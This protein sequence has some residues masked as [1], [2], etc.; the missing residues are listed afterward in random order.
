ML[1]TT[2]CLANFGFATALLAFALPPIAAQAP[3]VR[4]DN[5]GN[6]GVGTISPS[7]PLHV[8]DS[9]AGFPQLFTLEN[10]GSDFAGFRL[11]TTGGSIDFNKA[12]GNTFR[13]NIVDGDTW[14]LQLNPDGDL[15]IKGSI[16]TAGSC[17][18][19]CDRVFAP[20][21]DLPTI[22]E[23]A[24]AMWRDS[25]LPAVGPTEEGQ[26]FNLSDKTGRML[27]EL[28]KAHIYIEQLNERLSDLE[29]QNAR[30]WDEQTRND[31]LGNRL[32]LLENLM[33]GESADD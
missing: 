11:I 23:H 15:T 9:S 32:A 26:P 25:H 7:T 28:E 16:F 30:L 6:V 27:N 33:L 13:L 22:E 8:L 24:E 10:T 29:E 14:E 19:G 3:A 18:A 2:G 1:R 20:D 21:Y 5:N 31:E 4:V 12:G 17:S